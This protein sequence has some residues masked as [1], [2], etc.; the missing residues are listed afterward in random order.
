MS[1]KVGDDPAR[2]LPE[3]GIRDLVEA[4]V[5][6]FGDLPA[7]LLVVRQQVE[8][9]PWGDLQRVRFERVLEQPGEGGR[10]ELPGVLTKLAEHQLAEPLIRWAGDSRRP[11]GEGVLY[12][13]R[14]PP[15]SSGRG[16]RAVVG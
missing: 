8:D 6:V 16:S 14:G 11:P 13:V 9:V 12:C 10:V 5:H 7:G 4:R 3:I 1:K 2:P 15:S